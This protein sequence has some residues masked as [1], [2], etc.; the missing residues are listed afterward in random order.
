MIPS[1]WV[2][3]QPAR[4]PYVDRL[5][6]AAREV[7]VDDIWDVAAWGSTPVDIVHV[8]FGFET[9]GADGLDAW[10]AAIRRRGA[11]LVFTL[12]DVDNPHLQD[13]GP[14]HRLVTR[15]LAG[16]DRVVTLT[17]TAAR[18]AAALGARG[19]VEVV[20]HPHVVPFEV[21]ARWSTA[22]A[23]RRNVYVHAGTIRPNFDVGLL[24]AIA[25]AARELPDLELVVHVR[26]G[27]AGADEVAAAVK[28]GRARVVVE[29]R[30]DDEELWARL[31]GARVVAL[32]YRWGT[33]SGLVEAAHD[34]G[35]PALAPACGAYGDQ[36]AVALRRD[37]IVGSLCRALRHRPPVTPA[38]R[39]RQLAAVVDRHRQ[40]YRAVAR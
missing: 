19:P 30:P 33:H 38:G 32:P 10:I 31:A 7:T 11:A 3:Q 29:E 28:P 1:P 27:A 34:L 26:T 40:L 9:L 25:I 24:R 15:L 20:S 36:G 16:A 8:H 21:I 4:H 22:G 2:L 39:R 12:H 14:Y 23:A 6:P 37:D 17:P 35:T 13:Q 5:A 18:A